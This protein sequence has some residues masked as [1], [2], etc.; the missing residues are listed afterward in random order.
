[1]R[2]YGYSH[3]HRY[4]RSTRP[5]THP[6]LWQSY[7]CASQRRL[8]SLAA[9]LA[10]SSCSLGTGEPFAPT[11]IAFFRVDHVLTHVFGSSPVSTQCLNCSRVQPEWYEAL[12]LNSVSRQLRSRASQYFC[13]I[14]L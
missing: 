1:M 4:L 8:E 14:D 3:T 12:R 5:R 7:R 13:P 10:C 2:A 9:P 11:L 6:S